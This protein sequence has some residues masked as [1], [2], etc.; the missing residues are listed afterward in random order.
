MHTEIFVYI[1]RTTTVE[2]QQHIMPLKAMGLLI[3]NHPV[4][5]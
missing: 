1:S 3:R 5:M 2:I 4:R